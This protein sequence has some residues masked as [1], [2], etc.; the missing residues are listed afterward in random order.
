LSSFVLSVALQPV[1]LGLQPA[2]LLG[3]LLVA[4]GH[5]RE[6]VAL[7][8]DRQAQPLDLVL[9]MGRPAAHS[10]GVL[11]EHGQAI[12]IRTQ[13]FELLDCDI[14][15]SNQG[16]HLVTEPLGLRAEGREV[17]LELAPGR[18]P[19]LFPDPPLVFGLVPFLAGPLLELVDPGPEL[20]LSGHARSE[21]GVEAIPV[22][23]ECLQLVSRPGQPEPIRFR[24]LELSAEPIP[25][26]ADLPYF[27]RGRLVPQL[28][29]LGPQPAVLRAECLQLRL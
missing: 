11:P 10:L 8:L 7:L 24:V 13:G 3:Q 17:P 4:P 25:L 22:A 23:A 2:R 15:L 16:V 12:A 27:L 6:L 28:L 1:E 14:P 19:P 21:D 29:D 26:G 18:L 20:L 5:R 9:M